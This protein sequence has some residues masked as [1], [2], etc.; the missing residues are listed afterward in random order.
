MAFGERAPRGEPEGGNMLS[1]F[2]LPFPPGDRVTF[3]G[4]ECVC[5]KCSLPPA[6][7]GSSAPL[8]QG[9]W[10]KWALSGGVGPQCRGRGPDSTGAAAEA[11]QVRN[12]MSVRREPARKPPDARGA[13]PLHWLCPRTAPVGCSCFY[14]QLPLLLS[15]PLCLPASRKPPASS[16]SSPPTH[17]QLPINSR[18]SRGP[19]GEPLAEH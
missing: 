7:A 5:Q 10:S 1:R 16:C 2:R 12:C 6:V 17:S 11:A 19:L 15:A 9:L 3:N 18:P 4:K 8:S 13:G 14:V